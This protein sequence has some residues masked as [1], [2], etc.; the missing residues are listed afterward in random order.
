[1]TGMLW[2]A[3]NPFNVQDGL[4][5]FSYGNDDAVRQL[6][7]WEQAD[8][9]PSGMGLGFSN[10][11]IRIACELDMDNNLAGE[12]IYIFDPSELKIDADASA[13]RPGSLFAGIPMQISSLQYDAQGLAPITLAATPIN[14]L[15]LEMNSNESGSPAA[16][17]PSPWITSSP[18]YALEYDLPLG[19]LGSLSGVHAGLTASFYLGWGPS[20]YIPDNDAAAIF[21]K[22]P[23]LDAGYKGFDLQGVLKTTFGDAN[24]T[25]VNISESEYVYALMFNNI[26]LS[27]F[28]FSFPPGV[29]VNFVLFAGNSDPS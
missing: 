21:I 1:M 15:E 23:A 3:S 14:C 13:I 9:R 22:L 11:M 18:A 8:D 16:N 19:S 2:F 25:R 5:L 10:L 6:L 24:L 20:S 27:V 17:Q 7:P 4:D 29:M 28:G 26:A 12:R